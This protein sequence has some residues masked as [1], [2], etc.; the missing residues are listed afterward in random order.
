M[1]RLA[2]IHNHIRPLAASAAA[3]ASAATAASA[4]AAAGPIVETTAGHRH[5]AAEGRWRGPGS[6]GWRGVRADHALH[7]H[8]CVAGVQR[9]V[10]TSAAATCNAWPAPQPAYSV[11]QLASSETYS[12][13]S[14]IACGFCDS[15]ARVG[16]D[17]GL[18]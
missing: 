7:I 17:S 10:P 6:A 18:E 2:T 4:T 3:S 1:Q 9:T 15:C 12:S 14:M 8:G 11:P 13:M 5:A 16:F